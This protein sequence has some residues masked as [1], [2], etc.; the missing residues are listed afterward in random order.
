MMDRCPCGRALH[1]TNPAT[2]AQIE[3]YIGELGADIKVETAAGAWMVPRHYLALHGLK[4]ADLPLLA[5]VYGWQR[6]TDEGD[7]A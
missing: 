4:A 5:A 3:R 7:A 6:I 2:Q 1:Y